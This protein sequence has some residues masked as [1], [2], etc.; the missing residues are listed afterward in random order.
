MNV[1]EADRTTFRKEKA[2]MFIHTFNDANL[3]LTVELDAVLDF[4]FGCRHSLILAY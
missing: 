1:T 2:H 3:V 4:G